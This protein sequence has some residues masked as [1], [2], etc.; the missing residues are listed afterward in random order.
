[1]ISKDKNHDYLVLQSVVPTTNRKTKHDVLLSSQCSPSPAG[2]SLSQLTGF[3]LL[4][5]GS[6]VSTLLD[7]ESYKDVQWEIQACSA[8]EGLGLQQA[9][10]SVHRMIKKS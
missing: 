7:L 2:F 6:Q 4:V 1:M 3:C 8:V 5:F 9:F 10:L